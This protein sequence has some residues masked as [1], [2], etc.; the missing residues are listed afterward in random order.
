M[1]SLF[2]KIL[3]VLS[4]TLGLQ[5]ET[6]SQ[7]SSYNV[8]STTGQVTNW[9]AKFIFNRVSIYDSDL[10]EYTESY[11]TRTIVVINIYSNGTGKLFTAQNGYSKN[12]YDIK[13]CVKYDDRFEFI[14]EPDLR[15]NETHKFI[16]YLKNNKVH[17][18]QSRGDSNN[19]IV[20][21]ALN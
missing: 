12:D 3:I 14:W 11:P 10:K 18:L 9:E 2:K 8:N 1:L 7:S 13:S 19:R 17:Q 15:S 16:L 21:W 20:V 5:L 6:L 4:L